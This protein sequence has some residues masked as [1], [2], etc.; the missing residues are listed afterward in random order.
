MAKKTSELVRDHA[1]EGIAD[2]Y[3]SALLDLL[4][5]SL[6]R[7]GVREVSQR[8]KICEQFL[9]ELGTFHDQYW[10]ESSDKAFYPLLCFSSKFL[11]TDTNINALGA[12][13]APSGFYAFHEHA[14]RESR[15]LL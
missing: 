2:A 13:L 15:Q 4:N 12:V 14:H 8:R 9:L 3:Q 11:D 7:N 6:K 10:L 1:Y 5:E